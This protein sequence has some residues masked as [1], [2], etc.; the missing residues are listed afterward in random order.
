MFLVPR[1]DEKLENEP[2]QV[3]RMVR[4]TTGTFRYLDELDRKTK[5]W[6]HEISTDPDS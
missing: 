5:T 1:L 3:I 6:Y 2:F 4:F